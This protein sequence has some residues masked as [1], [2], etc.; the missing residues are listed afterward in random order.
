MPKAKITIPSEEIA[1]FCKKNHISKLSL[2][3]SVLRDD[4]SSD[5]DRGTYFK[6][7]CVYLISHFASISSIQL[8]LSCPQGRLATRH[9]SSALLSQ[10]SNEDPLFFCFLH[11]RRKAFQA[12]DSSHQFKIKQPCSLLQGCLISF[13]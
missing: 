10:G 7:N 5:S 9:H 4:F 2:F 12:S 6:R 3:G 13:I 1:E 8:N 11:R